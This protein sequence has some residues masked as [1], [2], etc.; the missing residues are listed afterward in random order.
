MRGKALSGATAVLI[1]AFFFLPWF[2]VSYNG[3]VVGQFSGYQLA[4][5]A[6]EY[7]LDGLNGRS[8]LYF[9]PLSALVILLW[10]VVA[11]LK[12]S[13]Q[14]IAAV[15]AFVTAMVGLALLLM[16]ILGSGENPV[17]GFDAELGL[18]LTLLCF[19]LA[20]VGSVLIFRESRRSNLVQ[21]AGN[22]SDTQASEETAVLLP[23]IPYQPPQKPTPAQSTSA[24]LNN[25]SDEPVDSPLLQ[26][27][28]VVVDGE[29]V[30]EKFRIM[31]PV[32]IGRDAGNN[33]VIDDSSMSGYHAVVREQGGALHVQDLNSTNGI[34]LENQA[35]HRWQR[36]P[37]ATLVNDMRIKLG[38]TVFRVEIESE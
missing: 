23:L 10:G 33:I 4:V 19:V 17:L 37:A 29:N 28:L 27:W 21:L 1:L 31:P 38:R 22:E 20:M 30:G 13:W 16:Q 14:L 9:I 34:Y 5:G 36:V 8:V 18:W 32:R 11:H 15:W 24:Q 12:P 26:T 6:G 7:A 3:R 2:S 35:N 25:L